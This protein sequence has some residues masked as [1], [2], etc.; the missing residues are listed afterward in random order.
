MSN[1]RSDT[2]NDTAET[3]EVTVRR[4][5]RAHDEVASKEDLRAGT[6]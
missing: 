4:C 3:H 6:E 2:G 5:L 1:T